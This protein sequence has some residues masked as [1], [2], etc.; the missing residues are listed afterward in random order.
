[1]SVFT[2]SCSVV[3]TSDL[4]VKFVL[5]RLTG[6]SSSSRRGPAADWSV[7]R[8]SKRLTAELL[9][10]QRL[11]LLRRGLQGRR[12]EVGHDHEELLEA[13]LL[14]GAHLVLALVPG[15]REE[16]GLKS[17]QCGVKFLLPLSTDRMQRDI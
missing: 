8:G 6:F 14:A 5:T 17:G 4:S 16:P 2:E 3:T 1:V 7:Q 12:A 15:G 9:S 11:L 13:D 10:P